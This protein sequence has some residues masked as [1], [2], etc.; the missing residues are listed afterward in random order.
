MNG[1]KQMVMVL[2][3]FWQID[4]RVQNGNRKKNKGHTHAQD[5]KNSIT[6]KIMK[7][8]GGIFF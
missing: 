7:K 8:N 1:E 4:L 2:R 3:A 6:K 5:L